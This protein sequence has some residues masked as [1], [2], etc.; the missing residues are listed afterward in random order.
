MRSSSPRPR[1][2]LAILLATSLVLSLTVTAPAQELPPGGTFT[3]DNGNTHE[4]Y[5]EAVAAAGITAGCS[6]DGTLY[7]PDDDVTRAQM[8]TFLARALDLTPSDANYFT[9]DNGSTHERNINAVAEAGITLGCDATGTLFCPNQS[10]SRQHMASFLARAISG[11]VPATRDYFTDDEIS[12]HQDNINIMAENGITLG[13]DVT[14]TLYCPYQ[15]VQRDQMATFLGRALDLTPII[16]PPPLNP[17]LLLV[18]S[19]LSGPLLGVAPS[20]DDRLFIVEKGGYIAIYDNGAVLPDK[21]LDVHTLVSTGGEQGLL[22]MAFHPDYASNSLFYISYTNTAGDSVVAEY[23]TSPGNANVA[24]PAPVRTII[25]VTQE[26]TNH[27]GGMIAFGPDGYLYFGLGDGGSGG[28]PNNRAEDPTTLLG[29]MLRL[30]I[31]GGDDFP[32]DPDRSYHIP[33]DNPF[34]GTSA[35]ADEVWAYGLRNPWR[36][37]F[38]DETNRLYI[39]DVGQSSREEVDVVDADEAGVN[40]GW[41]ILEGSLCHEPSS[42]CSSAGTQLPAWEYGRSDGQVIAGGF[43]YRGSA[44]PNLAG[45]YFFGDSGSLRVWSFSYDGHTVAASDVT[46]WTA[47]SGVSVWGFGQDDDGELYIMGGTNVYKIVP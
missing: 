11:L 43:V 46:H 13:C 2:P 22:G 9:D 38:D 17:Q 39:A 7:C 25:V 3:D 32:G 36:F 15:A 31:D 23:M 27:N 34:V 18:A 20:G 29:S 45:Q 21:F 14:G 5:I 26:F 1:L 33:S 8:A 16:P 42:G 19:G 4:G 47:L 44:I 10:V 41:D 30:D 12:V 40:Y 37:S 28:D 24:N 35:G 6:A